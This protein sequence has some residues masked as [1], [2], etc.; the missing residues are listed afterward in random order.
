MASIYKRR[1]YWYLQWS[2]SKGRHRKSLGKISKKSA[3]VS[4]KKKEN[5]IYDR[6]TYILDNMISNK[7]YQYAKSKNNIDEKELWWYLDTR[8]FGTCVHSGFGLGFERLVQFV[9]GMGNIRD[10]I[11]FPRFPGNA[12]F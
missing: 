8:K 4:L 6:V 11:P 2:D 5:K 1:D 10:V 3:E 12:E 7:A 9:T